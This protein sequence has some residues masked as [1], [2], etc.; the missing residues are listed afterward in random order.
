MTHW[1]RL[2]YFVKTTFIILAKPTASA[3]FKETRLEICRLYGK[4]KESS[5]KPDNS[6][7]ISERSSKLTHDLK[8]PNGPKR[9]DRYPTSFFIDGYDALLCCNLLGGVIT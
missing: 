7:R 3:S 2:S 8:R 4:T 5:R 6:T 1:K 9:S